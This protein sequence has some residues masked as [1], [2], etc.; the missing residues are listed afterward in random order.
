MAEDCII[1]VLVFTEPKINGNPLNNGQYKDPPTKNIFCGSLEL[2]YGGVLLYQIAWR[3]VKKKIY[4]LRI[5]RNET[6]NVH[7]DADDNGL[8][9]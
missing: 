2:R 5:P 1:Q 4:G 7:F 9:F 6:E 3:K 8:S